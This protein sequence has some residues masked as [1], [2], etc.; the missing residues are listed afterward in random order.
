MTP[1]RL[2]V[3]QHV[4]RRSPHLLKG[5]C[6]NCSRPSGID[7]H[8][9]VTVDE[10]EPERR[11]DV[12]RAFPGFDWDHGVFVLLKVSEEAIAGECAEEIEGGAT[13]CDAGVKGT[14]AGVE[15]YV[16]WWS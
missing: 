12:P 7:L 3:L 2:T 14:L 16:V 8:R 15:A 13:A 1:L 5:K 4:R 9:A 6:I 10:M 11:S